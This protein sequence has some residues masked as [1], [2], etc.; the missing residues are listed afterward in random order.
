MYS[1]YMDMK[2]GERGQVT[3]PQKF[4]RRLGLNQQTEVEFVEE[5]GRLILQKAERAAHPVDAVAGSC[6]GALR[7]LG[8]KSADAYLEATR[9]R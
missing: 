3:I 4:R 7:K 6:K 8:F 9:G 1:Y 2:I 5:R